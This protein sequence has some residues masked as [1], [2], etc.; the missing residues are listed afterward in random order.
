[1]RPLSSDSS[2]ALSIPVG[3][4]QGLPVAIELD[5]LPGNDSELLGFGIAVQTVIGRIPAPSFS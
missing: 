4:S 5:A 1:M 2:P 3:M